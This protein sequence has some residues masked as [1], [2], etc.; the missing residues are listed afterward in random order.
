VIVARNSPAVRGV[1]PEVAGTGV[2]DD[3]ES[4]SRGTNLDLSEILSVHVIFKW[5]N[6]VE[7][8]AL[9]GLSSLKRLFISVISSFADW[10]L[11]QR[12]SSTKGARGEQECDNE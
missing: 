1:H 8:V 5:D 3:C 4:L 10:S 6:L 2:G 9:E 11:G 7:P 12:D